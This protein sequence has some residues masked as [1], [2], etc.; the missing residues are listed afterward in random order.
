MIFG[1]SSFHFVRKREKRKLFH[2]STTPS[3]APRRRPK[4]NSKTKFTAFFFLS[5]AGKERADKSSDPLRVPNRPSEILLINGK[6]LFNF[7]KCEQH[8]RHTNIRLGEL[9]VIKAHQVIRNHSRAPRP[10]SCL[11]ESKGSTIRLGFHLD[12]LS[13]LNCCCFF[14]VIW[15]DNCWVVNPS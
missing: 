2:P 5:L 3:C 8:P 15:D 12:K 13:S 1:A 4:F 6:S 10:P 9:S 7:Q 11:E 14:L